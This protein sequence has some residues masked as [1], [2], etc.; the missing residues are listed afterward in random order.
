MNGMTIDERIKDISNRC[1]MSDT[2]VRAVLLAEAESAKES[3]KKCERVLLIGRATLNPVE[4][5][6]D[7]K[8]QIRVSAKIL[9]SLELE[10]RNLDGAEEDLRNS[11]EVGE[12]E[13]IDGVEIVHIESL[14]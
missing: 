9:Q 14:L 1:R 11:V 3:L 5:V 12:S 2:I 7:G 13:K 8:K 6:K 10:L 4:K